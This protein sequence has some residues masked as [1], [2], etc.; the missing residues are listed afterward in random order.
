MTEKRSEKISRREALKKIGIGAGFIAGASI[1]G[2]DH[3]SRFL[4]KTLNKE[5]YEDLLPKLINDLKKE[6]VHIDQSLDPEKWS[7]AIYKACEKNQFPINNE[8][9]GIIISILIHESGFR[10][11]KR[12]FNKI[13]S[14][15]EMDVNNFLGK[16]IKTAGPMQINVSY[17]M[18]DRGV[19]YEE[20]LS[21]INDIEG[22]MF[23]GVKYLKEISQIYS[24]VEDI[25]LRTLCMFT[26]YNAGAY[27]SRN[28]AIQDFLNRFSNV[29]LKED[30]LIKDETKK[31]LKNF[32]EEKKDFFN[33]NSEE[34]DE[35]LKYLGKDSLI[36]TNTW[37]LL[38]KYNS[39]PFL[40][41]PA[42]VPIRK[43]LPREDSS[44]EY[45]ENRFKDYLKIMEI[46][47][48]YEEE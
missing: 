4:N 33:L 11:D 6:F 32:I 10:I 41:I 13:P 19:D 42:N 45:G 15:G 47:K 35:N 31:V 24:K 2:W 40:P 25:E 36:Y 8:N 12:I 22:G 46:L 17:V 5:K 18:E 30:G 38:E 1:L 9:L 7:S 27:A 21:I 3:I 34:I 43:F 44:K 28:C 23:Y 20:A 29:K 14:P 37:K 39:K 16:K 48:K 26:D